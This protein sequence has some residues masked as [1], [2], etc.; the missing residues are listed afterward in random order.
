MPCF[1]IDFALSKATQLSQPDQDPTYQVRLDTF[2]DNVLYE[3]ILSNTVIHFSAVNECH[4]GLFYGAV[5]E[6][7]AD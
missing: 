5:V 3:S 7:V 4:S 6:V 1:T 2:P